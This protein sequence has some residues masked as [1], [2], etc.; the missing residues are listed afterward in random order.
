MLLAMK[1]GELLDDERRFRFIVHSDR[2]IQQQ[3]GLRRASMCHRDPLGEP[4]KVSAS[5][6]TDYG[7]S[8][9]IDARRVAVSGMTL[10]AV[11]AVICPT[12]M[13]TGSNT[14]TRRVA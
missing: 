5:W 3:D 11:P 14:F 2:K 1:R 6:A 12:V 10:A 9:R 4:R 13:T 8:T 7:D